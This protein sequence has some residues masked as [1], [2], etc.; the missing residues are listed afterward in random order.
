MK[1]SSRGMDDP[2]YRALARAYLQ[3]GLHEAIKPLKNLSPEKRRKKST[4]PPN[5]RRRPKSAPRRK[6]SVEPRRTDHFTAEG[7]E[8]AA[9]FAL[10]VSIILS[11]EALTGNA[12]PCR[13][14]PAGDRVR[15]G[16]CR[17]D[18]DRPRQAR[19]AHLAAAGP[20]RPRGPPGGAAGLMTT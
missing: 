8:S 11:P 12:F 14:L 13:P 19:R 9:T 4:R 7:K 1:G 6:R 17:I 5:F 15:H 20:A 3:V 16:R 10:N 18:C 2:D